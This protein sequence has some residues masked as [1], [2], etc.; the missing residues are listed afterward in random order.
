MAGAATAHRLKLPNHCIQVLILFSGT[1]V[2]A[3]VHEHLLRTLM[4][5]GSCLELDRKRMSF[6][7][8][9]LA[10]RLRNVLDISAPLLHRCTSQEANCMALRWSSTGRILAISINLAY[11]SISRAWLRG[12]QLDNPRTFYMQRE[13][14]T[15]I[16]L[17][18]PQRH[19]AR[20][21]S[22]C[23]SDLSGRPCG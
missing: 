11:G 7:N 8:T 19:T 22:N 15:R 1:F 14:Q 6:D 13:L 12:H 3:D 16:Y 23:I 4:A 18:G 2:G 21:I 5:R 10:T 9:T 17:C 20:I